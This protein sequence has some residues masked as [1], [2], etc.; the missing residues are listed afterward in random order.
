MLPHRI[1]SVTAVNG[2]R[3][4]AES[5]DEE[6]KIKRNKGSDSDTWEDNKKKL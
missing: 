6:E 5:T 4:V 2:D 1:S 3:E